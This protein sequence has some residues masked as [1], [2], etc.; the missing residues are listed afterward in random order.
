MIKNYTKIKALASLKLFIPVQPSTSLNLVNSQD[1]TITSIQLKNFYLK[2]SIAIVG[3]QSFSVINT[4]IQ[5]NNFLKQSLLSFR[6]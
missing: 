4:Q 5:I 6:R 3:D 2:M 1:N